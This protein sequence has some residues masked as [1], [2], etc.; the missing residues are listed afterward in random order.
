MIKNFF[1]NLPPVKDYYYSQSKS[2][3]NSDSKQLSKINKNNISTND[4][5]FDQ[6]SV[7]QSPLSK[8]NERLFQ[9]FSSSQRS[10]F[11]SLQQSQSGF[12]KSND[13]S[14]RSFQDK[15]MQSFVTERQ[16]RIIKIQKTQEQKNKTLLNF[17]QFSQ[18]ESEVTYEKINIVNRLS[19]SIRLGG[20]LNKTKSDTAFQINQES[21]HTFNQKQQ[22]QHINL[23]ENI[24]QTIEITP[25]KYIY[26]R[27]NISNQQLPLR[28]SCESDKE[29]YSI[30]FS[31]YD[32]YPDKNNS[33]TIP[34]KRKSH[35]YKVG[36]ETIQTKYFYF[37][38][39]SEIK[40]QVILKVWF[41]EKIFESFRHTKESKIGIKAQQ[42]EFQRQLMKKIMDDKKLQIQEK[43]KAKFMMLEQIREEK[44]QGQEV[45]EQILRFYLNQKL[46]EQQK[47][48]YIERNKLVIQNTQVKGMWESREQKQEIFQ[49]H[50]KKLEEAK[51][52]YQ[53][54]QSL[55]FKNKVQTIVQKQIQKQIT[56][57]QVKQQVK[58]KKIQ[59]T[60][61]KWLQI[62]N[63]IKFMNQIVHRVQYS[64]ILKVF[65]TK[66]RQISQKI[67]K[68]HQISLIKEPE[69]YH[70][71]MLVNIK[72]RLMMVK[73][74]FEKGLES[75]KQ[76]QYQSK[77]LVR[78]Q[79]VKPKIDFS[80]LQFIIYL[81]QSA[82]NGICKNY[83]YRQLRDLKMRLRE[84]RNQKQEY[85]NSLRHLYL[86]KE[87][88]Q[89]MDILLYE[90]ESLKERYG[91]EQKI[92]IS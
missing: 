41:N 73:I 11:S 56:L 1:N 19:N 75:L 90:L 74:L 15:Y 36:N 83:I 13:D 16:K 49:Q 72:R 14:M 91:S 78:G 42:K 26:A 5:K 25:K 66:N 34:K 20:Q 81:K 54:I 12:S 27:I 2:I 77:K 44:F 17:S 33:I 28:F 40:V 51:Q 80:L 7:I 43:E 61:L 88:Q 67:K 46:K 92:R 57:D 37:S 35:L 32:Q 82:K 62:L 53:F 68:Q 3:N 39:Y 52:R 30:Y 85:Q 18:E 65:S 47:Q 63:L 70:L 8:S 76:Q 69:S 55:N 6:D 48:E 23:I 58:E 31:F 64:K 10:F 22:E 45:E 38:F 29:D 87:R 89:L 60:C 24:K 71:R 50:R 84:A 9:S 59:E 21:T 4:S 79:Q 86:V